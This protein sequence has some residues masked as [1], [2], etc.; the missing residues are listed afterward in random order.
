M[1]RKKESSDSHLS[2]RGHERERL[3]L[4][5]KAKWAYR[6]GFAVGLVTY[7]EGRWIGEH[8]RIYNKYVDFE[9][10]TLLN[11]GEFEAGAPCT[12]LR[13]FEDAFFYSRRRRRPSR[14]LFLCLVSN[15]LVAIGFQADFG[16]LKGEGGANLELAK[17]WSSQFPLFGSVFSECDDNFFT[18]ISGVLCFFQT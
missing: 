1:L 9:S 13:S 4:A 6:R 11:G 8:R 17:M 18:Y 10:G 16:Q 2:L 12:K 15:A 5:E 14:E 7:R 3:T